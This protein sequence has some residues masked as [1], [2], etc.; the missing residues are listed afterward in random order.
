MSLTREGWSEA[1]NEKRDIRKDNCVIGFNH[2]LQG[3]EEVA[4]GN[5]CGDPDL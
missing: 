2:G 5:C 3:L 1:G 4:I